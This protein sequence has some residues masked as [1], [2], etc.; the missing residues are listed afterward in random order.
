MPKVLEHMR[1]Q[2]PARGLLSKGKK[3]VPTVTVEKNTSSNKEEYK[4]RK[5]R[6]KALRKAR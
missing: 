2:K 6:D 1:H 4:S 5:A 3:S